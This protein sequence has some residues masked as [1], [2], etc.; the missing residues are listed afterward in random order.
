MNL[1]AVNK[2]D[3]NHAVPLWGFTTA[4]EAVPVI[5]IAHQETALD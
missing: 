4:G 3:A 2:L 1:C 5:P